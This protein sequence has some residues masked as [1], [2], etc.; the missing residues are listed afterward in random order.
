MD[1]LEQNEENNWIVILED[2]LEN[3][4]SVEEDAIWDLLENL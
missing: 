1:Y 4:Y 3:T 2:S